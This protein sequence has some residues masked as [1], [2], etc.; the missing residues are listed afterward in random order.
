[1][2]EGRAEPGLFQQSLQ[3]VDK[4]G[5]GVRYQS[6]YSNSFHGMGVY[7]PPAVVGGRGGGGGGDA[8]GQIGR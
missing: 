2:P 1:V 3:W 4:N 5:N 7:P 8:T 6:I